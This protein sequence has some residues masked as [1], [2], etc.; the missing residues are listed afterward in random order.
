MRR[1]AVALGLL[2]LAGCGTG[3]DR[4]QA[5]AATERFYSAV[6]REDGEAACRELAEPAVEALEEQEGAA[7]ER[8]VLDLDL[9]GRAITGAEVAVTNAKV[10]LVP[11]EA[12]FLSRGPSGWKLSAVGCAH[13][14]RPA[15]HPYECELEA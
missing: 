3:D 13:D 6:E 5:R 11:P 7:C 8:A 14:G 9:E 12:A 15:D 1:V 2:A 4:D 10:D